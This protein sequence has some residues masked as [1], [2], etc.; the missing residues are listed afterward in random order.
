MACTST[1]TRRRRGRPPNGI[2]L[3][4]LL[5]VVAIIGLLVAL[6][7]PAVELAREAARRSQCANHLKQLSLAAAAHQ[8]VN[9]FFPTGGWGGGWVGDANRGFGPKQPGG[10]I[11][12][13]LPYTE[14]INL[15]NLGQGLA[16][17]P[18]LSAMMA[19]DR[20]ALDLKLPDAPR[21]ARLCECLLPLSKNF[22]RL[23]QPRASTL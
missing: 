8:D 19:R 14:Q 23:R 13:V 21:C 15:H 17:V 9:Q 2:T 3:V 6:L 11:Y 5:V 22:R 12:N 18:R 16:G 7:L 1:L 4:E 10:W 20:T